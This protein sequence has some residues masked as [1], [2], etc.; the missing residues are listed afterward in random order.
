MRP[1]ASLGLRLAAVLLGLAAAAPASS[2][3][4]SWSA[5]D[6]RARLD[7]AGVLHVVER[8]AM[9]FTGDWNGGE[10]IFRIRPGQSLALEGLA[11]IGPDGERHPLSAG[12]LSAVD[13][14]AWKDARTLRWRS[15]LPTDPAFEGTTLVY[16]IAYALSGI[17]VREGNG[18]LLDHDFAFPDR[19][20]PIEKFTLELE[21]DPA[22]RPTRPLGGSLSRGP[23]APGESVVLRVPLQ[24]AGAGRPVAGR[25]TVGRTARL[26]LFWILLAA[27]AALYGSFRT[28]EKALGR[29]APLPSPDAIDAR[30]LD[31]NL[32]CLAPEEAGALWDEKIGAPEVAAV[33][34]RLAADKKIETRVEGKNLT[35]RLLVAPEHLTGYDRDLVKALF[36]DG[37][38]ETDTDGIRKHYK[39]SG[40]DPAAKIRQGLE[41]RL[42][43]L[44]DA[45]ERPARPAAWPAPVLFLLGIGTLA[46]SVP[47]GKEDPGNVIGTAIFH[48][49]L[50]GVG[51][52]CALFFQKRVDRPDALSPIFLWV[53][54]LVL[55]LSWL[56]YRA[57][58]PVGPGLFAGVFLL[59]LAILYGVFNVAKSREGPRR[60][61]RRKA[62]AA[63]RAF[64][65]GELAR[66]A[67]G[68]KNEWYPW[69]VALGLTGAADRWFRAYGAEG[70]S[71]GSASGSGSASASS[72]TSSGS[73]TGGGGA[74]GGAG[75]SASW[76]AAAGALAAGVSAPS[77]SGGGGGGGGGGGSSGGGGGGGW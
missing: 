26:A 59:R 50:W 34:A 53:P 73:W 54:L 16:E 43:A 5:V 71:T 21:L 57:V 61:A 30:W 29:F 27:A 40:F 25:V 24:Y 1:R 8:Q 15:R 49:V 67:P 48:L 7:A 17:L 39:A 36:F 11:R 42:A 31:A 52:A 46:L 60:I 37:R 18:Y 9:V 3:E 62:L 35:M 20:G 55:W 38:Q 63:A 69:I 66:P 2:R 32:L 72:S 75:A 6:V 10:R 77:S 70:A 74:F 68:L 22:W 51:A 47:L 4:L 56:G 45:R 19:P 64:F 33:L 13:Q 58:S 65:A 12:D 44:P 28:R 41:Q 14:Y 76:A 23:L